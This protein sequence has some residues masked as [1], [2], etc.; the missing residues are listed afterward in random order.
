MPVSDPASRNRMPAKP[1]PAIYQLRLTLDGIA[2]AIVRR[3]QVHED[4]TLPQLH[5]YIQAVMNWECY[6]LH[7]FVINGRIYAEPDP[8]DALDERKVADERRIRLSKVLKHVGTAFEYRYDFGDGWEHDLLLEAI[9]MPEDGATY[10]RC[11]AAI[12]NAP[13]EDAGGPRGYLDYIDALKDRL[14]ERHRELRDWRGRF[15]PEFC[16]LDLLN[17]RLKVV[18]KVSRMPVLEP[19]YVSP[20]ARARMHG[21]N[22]E[23]ELSER[24]RDLILNHTFADE[25]LIRDLRNGT[26]RQHAH[27]Y[28][29]SWDDLDDLAGYIAAESNH[30][31]SPKLRQEWQRIFAKFTAVLDSRLV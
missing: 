11:I 29:F 6:H 21:R 28:R 8:D 16:S 31:R 1:H 20:Y 15:D 13:P 25:E 14:H 10:P 9:L 27:K 4:T 24:E 18:A 5:R 26:S 2:P 7:E 12:R 23:I 3:I 17:E 22:L 30:A 19:I